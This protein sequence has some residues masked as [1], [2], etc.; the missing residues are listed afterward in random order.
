MENFTISVNSQFIISPAMILQPSKD[1]VTCGMKALPRGAN[2][3]ASCLYSL[4]STIISSPA[5]DV[6]LFAD[7]SPGQ[8]GN[9]FLMKMLS[10]MVLKN[11]NLVSS[12]QLIFLEKGHTQTENV[13]SAIELAKKRVTIYHPFQWVTLVETSCKT[14]TNIVRY[15][16]Q[17]DV[18]DFHDDID[19]IYTPINRN[20]IKNVSGKR[21]KVQWSQIKMVRFEASDPCKMLLKY[22]F[23][24]PFRC[25]V[26]VNMPKVT[27]GKSKLTA[28]LDIPK[29][30]DHPLFI[31]KKKYDGLQKL[32]RTLA[33]PTFCHEFYSN[34]PH[35]GCVINQDNDFYNSD[36][37]EDVQD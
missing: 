15:L 25:A 26:V 5:K 4:L 29:A 3:I 8:N 13:H 17:S 32:C 36:L 31:S 2:E 35:A 33:I 18:L 30:Y 12:L 10:L 7:N 22:H 27:R 28:T 20:T 14:K 24:E 9:R 16:N 21:M 1:T 34:L 19:G 23:D 6:T 11:G 37:D